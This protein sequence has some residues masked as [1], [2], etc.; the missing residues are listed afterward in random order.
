MLP[1]LVPSSAKCTAKD[2]L[3]IAK[4]NKRKKNLRGFVISC[5]P[6]R[7]Y[8]FKV[9][10]WS[11]RVRYENCSR[12][13]IKTLERFQKRRCSVFIVNCEHISDLFLIVDFE[14]A[15]VC[16]AHIEK[17]NTFEEKIQY[18]MRYV[19]V[20]SVWTKFIKAWFP[21]WYSVV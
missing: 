17:T 5:V 11:A 21:Q 12:L 6:A 7:N 15:N 20:F 10:N 2:I 1:I 14:Q 19:V 3:V 16:W 18:I 8:L 13:R 4:L 9:S